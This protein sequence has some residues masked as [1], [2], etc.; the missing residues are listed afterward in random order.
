MGSGINNLEKGNNNGVNSRN[1]NRRVGGNDADVIR[2]RGRGGNQRDDRNKIHLE[3][4]PS[5]YGYVV[6]SIGDK[7]TFPRGLLKSIVVTLRM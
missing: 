7:L 4:S 1:Q 3:S 5:P 6:K 2:R